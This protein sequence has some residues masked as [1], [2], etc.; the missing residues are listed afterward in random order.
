MVFKKTIIEINIDIAIKL[1]TI[2]SRVVYQRRLVVSVLSPYTDISYK[3]E[4]NRNFNEPSPLGVFFILAE[5]AFDST[6]MILHRQIELHKLSVK[7]WTSKYQS[8]SYHYYP[9]QVS[10]FAITRIDEES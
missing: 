4:K 7:Y 9:D 3:K 2:I 1:W 8:F 5:T 6:K 10:R